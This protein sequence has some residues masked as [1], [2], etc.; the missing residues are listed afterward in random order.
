[1]KRPALTFNFSGI[2]NKLGI[3]TPKRGGG[4]GGGGN[5]GVV[6]EKWNT[7]QSGSFVFSQLTNRGKKLDG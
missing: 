5:D 1:M 4:D 2:T 7:C 6:S 3:T